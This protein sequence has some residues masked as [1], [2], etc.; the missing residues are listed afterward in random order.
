MNRAKD[1]DRFAGEQN[2][3]HIMNVAMQYPIP[4]N[5]MCK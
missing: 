3:A 2:I 1:K 4:E 5:R